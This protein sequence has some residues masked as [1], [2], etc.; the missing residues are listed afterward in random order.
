MVTASGVPRLREPYRRRSVRWMGLWKPEAWRIKVYGIAYKGGRPGSTLV[1]AAKD[2]AAE[3][4]PVVATEQG[5]Y[6]VGFLGIH[7]GRGENF[8]FVD[9]WADENELHHH[10]YASRAGD[11]A[12]LRYI[13]P[14]GIVAC[15]WDL[16]V[17]AFERQA[18]IDTVLANPDGPDLDAY[19]ERRF[20]GDV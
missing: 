12:A 11:P 2:V 19:L 15:C 7:E 8:V 5:R 1:E 10:V 13:T 14:T 20:E 6:G 9:W 18:W 17:M 3:R 4:L 16:A